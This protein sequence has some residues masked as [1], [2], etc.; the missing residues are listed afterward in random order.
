MKEKNPIEPLLNQV[1]DLLQKIQNYDKPLEDI[2]KEVL[3]ELEALEKLFHRFEDLNQKALTQANIDL[4]DL[5]R[6][7][8]SP[9]SQA[10]PKDKQLL[11]KSIAMEKDIEQMKRYLTQILRSRESKEPNKNKALKE[12]RKKYKSL[13]GDKGWIRL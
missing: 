11:E 5:K 6:S 9:S 1:G 8:L 2:P 12:R 7:A 13:G 3:F 4:D 10:S